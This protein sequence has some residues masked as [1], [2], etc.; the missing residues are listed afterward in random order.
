M[1]KRLLFTFGILLT[2]VV[3]FAQ[4]TISGKVTDAVTKEPIP[5]ASVSIKGTVLGGVADGSGKF[6][7]KSKQGF[8]VTVSVG[9]IG[10]LTELVEVK[11]ESPLSVSLKENIGTLAE[12]TVTGNRVEESLTKAST[13]IEK[14]DIRKITQSASADVYGAL[15]GLKGVDLLAQNMIFR[16][17]NIRGF[18][19]NN[20][21]RFVQ[22]TDGMDN[23]SP[24]YGFGFGNVAG[25][26]D[27][28]IESIEILPG[29]ASALYGPDALQGL[30]LTKTK[31][32]FEYQG[33]SAQIKGGVNNVGKS[34]MNATPYTDIAVRYAKQVGD[35][36]AFKVNFQ[37]ING[38]DFIADNFD[39]RSHRGRPGFFAVDNN[40]KTVGLGFVPNNDPATNF[41]YDGVNIYG[42]DFN[43]GGAFTFPATYPAAPGL[44]GK[45]V[46]RTGYTELELL[47]NGGKIFSYR[48]NA[49][50]HYKLTDKIEAI[51]AWYFGN[52]NLVRTG[53]FREFYPDYLRNQFKL[54]L[55]GD[56]FFVRGYN[57]S[58]QAEGYNLGQLSARMLQLWKPTAA[59]GGDFG[60]SYGANSDITAS[61]NAA[62]V[63]KPMPGDATFAQYYNALS[64]TL[65]NEFILGS[66]TIRGV[67][68]LDNSSLQHY[69][70]MYNFKNI[71]PSFLEVVTGASF[72]KYNLLTKG[73][74][75]PKT[76]DGKEFTINEY[77]WYLQASPT[78]KMTEKISLKPTVAVRYDKNE[79][80]KGGFTP[81]V[82]GV[83]SLGQH[84]FRGSWQSAFRNSSANQLL[85]DGNI[86]EVGGSEAALTAANLFQNPAYT[87]AS[88][89]LFN[90][91][92]TAANPN[93][94]ASLLT[95][96]TPNPG[97]FATEKI[98]T[99]EIGYK[100]LINNKLFI[101]AFY[102]NSVYN[103]FIATQNYRQ[104]TDGNILNLNN[105]FKPYQ[106]NFNNFNQIY[107]TGWGLG[108]EYAVGKGY[109]IG[110]NFANQ[111][112]KITLKNNAGVIVKDA[113]GEEIVKR[114]MSDPSVAR[115]QRNFFIS[116]E[117]R[118]NITFSNPRV[119]EKIGFT[120]NYRW[121]DQ[122]W[123]EQG[124]TAGDIML[125]SWTSLDAAVSYKLPSN[126]KIKVGGSNI[127]NKYYA[128]GYGLANIG[129][130]YYV[131]I[132]YN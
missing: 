82:S 93:G 18:G 41:T 30:M 86:G 36:L 60:R 105:S 67:R 123:V 119:T 131:S 46:T 1:T 40:A 44:V 64:T 58:Q 97:A 124:A 52:G 70:G 26:S 74:I 78:I 8:P 94:D 9:A 85:A 57:T 132:G 55:K 19:A 21:N 122:M 54:E 12:V 53:G 16:S 34:T 116:P 62:D 92:R 100:T 95:K 13:T 69:E 29:A 56:N 65:S 71:L 45:Q 11:D 32:P 107:V 77:G 129:G 102:F 98:K 22:L 3:G 106:I 2:T 73:T 5:G 72:R 84:N 14:L 128:Q 108:A 47:N 24:G 6:S 81:R 59:W 10:F 49:A 114:K 33:L 90:A 110:F 87:E 37:A 126:F 118:Y 127:L 115:V 51:A 130:M 101:D 120:V 28:D 111:V 35:K 61:R 91:S 68:V 96:Y 20:N 99:W 4:S 43:N 15:Q 31:S 113:F 89:N 121:T 75:F 63:G 88:A 48:A 112:G 50:V 25:V 7:I 23:R 104:P 42:D 79:Y 83:L 27:I 17:V 109:N 125:P 66:T 117:N 76:K 103:D 39:D 38:T 80:F